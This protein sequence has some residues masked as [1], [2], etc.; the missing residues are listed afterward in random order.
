MCRNTASWKSFFLKFTY[1][2]SILLFAFLNLLFQNFCRHNRRIPNTCNIPAR[3]CKWLRFHAQIFYSTF[4]RF[5]MYLLQLLSSL[6]HDFQ[7]VVS[8]M[9]TTILTLH[10]VIV[11]T[12]NSYTRCNITNYFTSGNT[13]LHFLPRLHHLHTDLI[14]QNVHN[15]SLIGSTINGKTL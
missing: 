6:L 14:I 5:S 3:L 9:I 7:L 13:Q 4:N 10:V 11:I 15:I 8:T 1:Y 12:Y 2:A